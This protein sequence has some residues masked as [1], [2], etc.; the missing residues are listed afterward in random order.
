MNSMSD[1]KKTT[2]KI[3]FVRGS[4]N[5]FADLGLPNP[6]LLQAKADLMHQINVEIKRRGL[7]Q[8]QAAAL[9]GMGQSDISNMN[10]GHG[11]SYSIEK[12]LEALHKLGVNTTIHLEGEAVEQDIPVYAHA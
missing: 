12:L 7:T 11:R 8:K 3:E 4:G 5:V 9:I 2:E 10:R 1:T 6:E